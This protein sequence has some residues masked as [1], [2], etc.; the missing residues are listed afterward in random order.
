M[1]VHPLVC[2]IEREPIIEEIEGPLITE[3]LPGQYLMPGFGEKPPVFGYRI[4][5]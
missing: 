1:R 4:R 2:P 3:C 5:L